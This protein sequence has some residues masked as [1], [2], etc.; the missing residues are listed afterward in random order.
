MGSPKILKA[1]R[2]PRKIAQ[3][4]KEG[5]VYVLGTGL[6]VHSQRLKQHIGGPTEIAAM[7]T[8]DGNLAVI[9]DPQHWQ[10]GNTPCQY[11]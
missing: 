2:G 10:P 6:K 5:R 11:V 1:W 8:N 9:M 4:L 3:A 7:S